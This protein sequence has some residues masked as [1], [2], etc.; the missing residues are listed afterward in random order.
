VRAQRIAGHHPDGAMRMVGIAALIH[1][2][3]PVRE[4]LNLTPF[5]SAAAPWI[6]SANMR[7]IFHGILL[8]PKDI[9]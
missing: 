9:D 2:Q 4:P 5:R 6:L 3:Q 7:P 1:G 8:F